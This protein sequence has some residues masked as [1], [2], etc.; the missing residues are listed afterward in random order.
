MIVAAS[1]SPFSFILTQQTAIAALHEFAAVDDRAVD[2]S[3]V[4]ACFTERRS[5][6]AGLQQPEE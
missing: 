4:H 1:Q 2:T 5:G 6:D 3:A